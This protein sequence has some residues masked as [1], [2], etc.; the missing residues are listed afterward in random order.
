MKLVELLINE[1]SDPIIKVIIIRGINNDYKDHIFTPR[2]QNFKFRFVED[3][4]TI[5]LDNEV[6]REEFN[7]WIEKLYNT[8][9]VHDKIEDI[10]RTLNTEVKKQI[11][12]W[13][14]EKVLGKES[15]MGFF[16]ELLELKKLLNESDNKSETLNGWC[17]P[18]P[19]VHDFDYDDYS[20]EVKTIGRKAN[21]I[22]ISSE[23]QLTALDSK[24]LI[25]KVTEVNFMDKNETDSIGEIYS[26]IMNI[27]DGTQ[28]IVF[29][30][31][32]AEDFFFKYIGPENMPLEY[33][34]T[35]INSEYYDVDQLNFPRIKTDELANGISDIK[36]RV[37]VSSFDS[38]KK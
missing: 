27:L 31:K 37:D 38:F 13:S 36:Y 30:Q 34:I 5:E 23:D 1:T 7:D 26:E 18:A 11:F 14:K 16:G 29:E 10:I 8:L 22:K 9:K 32:C 2:L 21:S 12:F 3:Q 17:R 24:D 4:F 35:E 6:I 25:L 15:A 28:K 33:K 19:A 20:L